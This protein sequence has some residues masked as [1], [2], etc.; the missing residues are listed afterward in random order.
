MANKEGGI[1]HPVVT[2]TTDMGQRDYYVAQLK[3]MVLSALSDVQ[4]IDITHEIKS[5][6]I[7]EGAFI[8]KN[9][10]KYFPEKT[11]HVLYIND[12]DVE[13]LKIIAVQYQDH[14]FI[15]PDNGIFSL[16]FEEDAPLKIYHLK[17]KNGSFNSFKIAISKAIKHIAAGTAFSKLGR[18]VKMPVK[19][20]T[21]Q[22]VTGLNQINGTVIHIDKYGNAIVNITH[23]LFKKI[24]KQRPFELSFKGHKSMTRLSNNYCQVATGETVCFFNEQGFLEVAVNKGNAATLLSIEKEDNV[25]IMFFDHS[26]LEKNKK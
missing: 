11:I 12:L 13:D 4:I 6:D 21:L 20:I 22:P 24:G 18:K 16:I 3:G 17:T 19:R 8:F 2:L 7:V 10:W 1:L 15:G 5:F 14:Y 26:A 23:S 9:C 25:H